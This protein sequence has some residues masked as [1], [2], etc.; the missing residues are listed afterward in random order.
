MTLWCVLFSFC[1][2]WLRKIASLNS[3]MS[4]I[5]RTYL[6]MRSVS[7]CLLAKLLLSIGLTSG[8]LSQ[9]CLHCLMEGV[10]IFQYASPNRMEA[11]GTHFHIVSKGHETVPLWKPPAVAL[12]LLVRARCHPVDVINV[13]WRL[14]PSV[15]P[16]PDV[17]TGQY[18]CH[19]NARPEKQKIFALVFE[20]TTW[21][22]RA[23][24]I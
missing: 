6:D 12:D 13:G 1:G 11:H 15:I 4:S 16:P 22:F 8:S 23:V 9:L 19:Q 7:T 17:G 2:Q 24:N 3:Y 21:I 10:G 18:S 20:L 14:P 5:S